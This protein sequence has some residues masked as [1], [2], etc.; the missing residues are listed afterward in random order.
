M[1]KES[2]FLTSCC[3]FFLF[4]TFLCLYLPHIF[5]LCL[6]I[7]TAK[8]VSSPPRHTCLGMTHYF[9]LGMLWNQCPQINAFC[10]SDLTFPCMLCFFPLSRHVMKF[11]SH[12]EIWCTCIFC[13]V[14]LHYSMHWTILSKHAIIRVFLSIII[15]LSF[16]LTFIHF[17]G[18]CVYLMWFCHFLCKYQTQKSAPTDYYSSEFSGQ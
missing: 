14:L 9:F 12:N 16:I 7:S 2:S 15:S 1:R 5:K 11:Q 18:I 3:C 10:H 17:I 4:C 8:N 13:Y 6:E